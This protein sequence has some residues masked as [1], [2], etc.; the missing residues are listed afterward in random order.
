MRPTWTYP[1]PAGAQRR[2]G[3]G[4]S[5]PGPKVARPRALRPFAAVT[6]ANPGL[7]EPSG[8]LAAPGHW[9]PTTST[10]LRCG[11]V[12]DLPAVAVC[13]RGRPACLVRPRRNTSVNLRMCLVGGAPKRGTCTAHS[14]AALPAAL[15]TRAQRKGP[16]MRAPPESDAG[17]VGRMSDSRHLPDPLSA[18]V[19]VLGV[20]SSVNVSVPV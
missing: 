6:T 4:D 2:P 12:A 7:P 13:S 1:A 8:S 17:C 10:H 20:A 15:L 18:T 5:S 16:A 9:S 11:N 14:E 19:C 3:A